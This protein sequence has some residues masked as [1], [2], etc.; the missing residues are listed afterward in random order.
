MGILDLQ[1]LG[2]DMFF[3][4]QMQIKKLKSKLIYQKDEQNNVKILTKSKEQL[5]ISISLIYDKLKE[6]QNS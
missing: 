2:E 5:K 6:K 3:T 1:R 4:I